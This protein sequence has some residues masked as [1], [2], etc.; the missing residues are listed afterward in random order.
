MHITWHGYSV[1]P[2]YWFLRPLVPPFFHHII[3][4]V[5]AHGSRVTTNRDTKLSDRCCLGLLSQTLRLHFVFIPF[6]TLARLR[7]PPLIIVR[8]AL[9]KA[10]FFHLD[11]K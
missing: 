1:S 3:S 4:R 5:P 9:S 10:I 6:Q 8:T 11:S 7:E 2:F